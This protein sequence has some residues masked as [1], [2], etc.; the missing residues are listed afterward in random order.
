M[1]LDVL[2]ALRRSVQKGVLGRDEV[3]AIASEPS[4]A[5]AARALQRLAQFAGVR[6]VD[7]LVAVQ[8]EAQRL[9]ADS[10]AFAPGAT[11]P[12]T[13][14]PANPG[15]T[16]SVATGAPEALWPTV[17]VRYLDKPGVDPRY[18]LLYH[19]GEAIRANAPALHQGG[20]PWRQGHPD[21]HFEHLNG[22]DGE[23]RNARITKELMDAIFARGAGNNAKGG[24]GYY[25]CNDLLKWF[26]REDGTDLLVVEP[27]ANHMGELLEGG[28]AGPIMT[29]QGDINVVIRRAP[30]PE[31][32]QRG[33]RLLLR[34]PTRAD[35]S[36]MFPHGEASSSSRLLFLE[37]V[38][39]KHASIRALGIERRTGATLAVF[40]TL[41]YD[42]GFEFLRSLP[43]RDPKFLAGYRERVA[44][45]RDAFVLASRSAE[46]SH[47]ERLPEK[48]RALEAL[49]S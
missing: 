39:Q 8:G 22:A 30:T 29:V 38:L 45:I 6:S 5:D 1:A 28:E 17:A 47:V 37:A 15:G 23:I 27:F 21:P 9:L 11:A 7:A 20:W 13:L 43:E 2:T 12:V 35:V 34:P 16:S 26:A 42:E 46:A 19:W 32:E 10:E 3:R 14:S 33:I 49:L 4:G 31:E 25:T 18:T 36:H 40:R 44:R 24:L 48:V 41:I